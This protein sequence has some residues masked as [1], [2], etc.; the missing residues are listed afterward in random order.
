MGLNPAT[1]IRPGDIPIDRYVD[2]LL[3][4]EA[5]TIFYESLRNRR[6]K[7]KASPT[8]TGLNGMARWLAQRGWHS[9]VET[10]VSPY[11]TGRGEELERVSNPM[12]SR[13]IFYELMRV[14]APKVVILH[15]ED[16]LSEFTSKLGPSLNSRTD[17]F[18]DLVKKSPYLGQVTWERGEQCEVFVCPHLRFF[19]HKGGRRF[20]PLEEALSTTHPAAQQRL[21]ADAPRATRR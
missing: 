19:G 10:N 7:T 4:I 18:S 14:L 12:Q 8:R 11:P 9:V 15:G 5:F 16:A 2:L 21:A 17:S 6:G 20:G 13:H 1:D 3:D